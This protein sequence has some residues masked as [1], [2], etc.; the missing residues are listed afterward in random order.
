MQKLLADTAVEPHALRN[1]LDIR[2]YPLAECCNLVDEGDF[3]GE[4]GVRRILDEFRRL[5]PRVD[6]RKVP[7]EQRAVDVTHDMAG[8]LTLE[9]D[10]HPI[11]PH[12]VIDCRSLLAG[13]R[14]SRRHR[15]QPRVSARMRSATFRLIPTGTVDLVTTTV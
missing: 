8:P 7:Q 14:G 2:S 5:E 1:G 10:H 12:E 15:S 4:E 9:T 13:T 3:R 11:R 6:D